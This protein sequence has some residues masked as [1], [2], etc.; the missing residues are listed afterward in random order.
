MDNELLEKQLSVWN[1]LMYMALGSAITVVASSPN[2]FSFVGLVWFLMQIAITPPGFI[3]LWGKP[4]RAFPLSKE[5]K[6]TIFGYFLASWLL[7][8][9]PWILDGTYITG[10]IPFG[11]T[12]FLAVVYWR[13]QK[14]LSDSDE[15]FP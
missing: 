15:I 5:R 8:F 10:L 1:R 14:K 11:Y 12:I 9:V 4:W 6:N 3:L 2:D 7:L 13:N